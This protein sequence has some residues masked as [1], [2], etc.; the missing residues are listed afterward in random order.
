MRPGSDYLSEIRS[1]SFCLLRIP[2]AT[3]PEGVVSGE[4]RA[5]VSASIKFDISQAAR[6]PVGDVRTTRGD[7]KS[8]RSP[9][10]TQSQTPLK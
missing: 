5:G 7:E 10:N 8:P 2:V 9:G 4:C 3:F 6:K 1:A